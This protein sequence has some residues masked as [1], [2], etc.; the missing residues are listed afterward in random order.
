MELRLCL[1]GV[2]EGDQEGEVPDGLQDVAFGEGVL[3]HFPLLNDG[4]FLQ[5]L[6]GKQFSLVTLCDFTHQKH[7]AIACRMRVD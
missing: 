6:H 7:L 4:G 1:E 3:H 5:H 2:V